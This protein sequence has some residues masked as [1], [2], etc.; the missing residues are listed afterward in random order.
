MKSAV[1]LVQLD[2][3]GK[4]TETRGKDKVVKRLKETSKFG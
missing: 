1:F 3:A 4:N 2:Y